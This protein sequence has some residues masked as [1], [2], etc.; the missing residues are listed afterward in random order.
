MPNI[1]L[2]LYGLDCFTAT[3]S[4]T[5]LSELGETNSVAHAESGDVFTFDASAGT[6]Y[7]I[8]IDEDPSESGSRSGN[9]TFGEAN[10][11][12]ETLAVG[13]TLTSPFIEAQSSTSSAPPIDPNTGGLTFPA[14]TTAH[15][16]H[17]IDFNGDDGNSYRLYAVNFGSDG[18]SSNDTHGFLWDGG[19]PPNGTE[20]TYAGEGNAASTPFPY[21]FCAG[22]MIAVPGGARAVESLVPGSIV[23]TDAG[24]APV[25]W[26]GV[27]RFDADYVAADPRLRPVRISRALSPTMTGDLRLSQQHRV[28][29]TGS[30]VSLLF[31]IERA[32]C[33]A[34]ALVDGD[35]VA[36]ESEPQPVAYHHILLDRHAVVFANG[37]GAET[38]LPSL[39]AKLRGEDR[40][41]VA[42][43]RSEGTPPSPAILPVLRMQ[44]GCALTRWRSASVPAP[45]FETHTHIT[46]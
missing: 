35:L 4:S 15:T 18:F 6:T 23:M 46:A 37:L 40:G 43:H 36:V 1:G 41:S 42:F 5:Q 38:L 10:G 25:R 21:C 45:S 22:T 30:D 2:R 26:T 34:R 44:E 3:G 19:P 28:L 27:Y 24:P 17:Y 9:T 33:P 13:F 31:G 39:G 16:L 12:D 29:V 8:V 7:G 11:T 14:G 32:L 20:L